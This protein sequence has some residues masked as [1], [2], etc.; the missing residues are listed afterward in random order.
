MH[1]RSGPLLVAVATLLVSGCSALL[2]FDLDTDPTGG[3]GQ[4][5]A[6][7]AVGPG[8]TT[9]GGGVGATGG[10]GAAGQGGAGG[11][12]AS[13]LVD[14]GLVVRY[15]IDDTGMT[16]ADAAP[17]PLPLTIT[18]DANM[19]LAGVAG[20]RGLV[21]QA[22]TGLGDARGVIT[23]TKVESMLHGGTAAT[24]E[25]VADVVAAPAIEAPFVTITGGG[26]AG[27]LAITMPNASS[28]GVAWNGGI[29]IG[30]WPVAMPGASRTVIHGVLDTNASATLRVRLYVNGIEADPMTN[31]AAPPAAGATVNLTGDTHLVVGNGLLT[32][33][34][35]Q[36]TL[37]Y[38]AYYDVALTDAEISENA[39]RLATS[40]DT[41]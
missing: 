1:L 5:G 35:F 33:R 32:A 31:T 24:L 17:Q 11:A 27:G 16:L 38:G 2:N 15:F 4:G 19:A 37:G 10:G 40:D 18:P 6:S 20:R 26:D 13:C 36:G 30:S 14:R 41:M 23:G 29:F 22:I 3:S 7:T 34:S 39:A 21:W 9:S 28:L 12:C 8:P 25:V